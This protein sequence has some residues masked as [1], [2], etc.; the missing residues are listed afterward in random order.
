MCWTF[1][2]N[3][4]AFSYV[5]HN[6]KMLIALT[7]K[8]FFPGPSSHIFW[9]FESTFMK[10]WA[11]ILQNSYWNC[12]TFW[13]FYFFILWIY[14]FVTEEQHNQQPKLIKIVKLLMY[15]LILEL[16]AVKSLLYNIARLSCASLGSVSHAPLSWPFMNQSK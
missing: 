12:L 8:L 5:F 15:H 6:F 2:W 1:F 4:V 11:L 14:S 13:S 16:K 9:L 7:V 3:L 10:S